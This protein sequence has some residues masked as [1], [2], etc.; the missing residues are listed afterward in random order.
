MSETKKSLYES[1]WDLGKDFLKTLDKPLA[2]KRD[3]LA[4]KGAYLE[5]EQQGSNAQKKLNELRESHIG[6]YSEVI[7]DIVKYYRTIRAADE[8]MAD[9]KLCYKETFGKDLKVE[10]E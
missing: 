10:E 8:A 1:L 2:R 3:I 7:D 6:K 4:F 5:A 9:I